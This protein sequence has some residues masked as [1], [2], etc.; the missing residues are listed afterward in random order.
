[1]TM[2]RMIKTILSSVFQREPRFLCDSCKYD[3]GTACT[4]RERPN[5]MRCND[6]RRK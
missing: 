3:Y 4:R 6:Y 1:M 5:A 2:I